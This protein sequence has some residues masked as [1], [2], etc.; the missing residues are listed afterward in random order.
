MTIALDREPPR[1]AADSRVQRLDLG[2]FLDALA[3]RDARI[4]GTAR[5]DASVGG[6]VG[7]DLAATTAGRARLDISDGVVHDFPLVAA[8]NRALRL[9]EGNARDTRF[10]RL[11]ASL[12]IGGG[13]AT[14]SD[15]VLEAGEIRVAASGRIGFDRTLNLR[16]TATLSAERTAEIAA[17]VRELARLRRNGT[18]DLPLA[19]TGTLDNPAFGIDLK[20][21]IERGIG[22][23]LLRRLGKFIRR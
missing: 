12:A 9:S 5:I 14:T 6:P 10:S 16:G 15:L 18:I 11:S 2:A 22:D 20:S 21:A 13:G 23:E 7:G 8:I 1:W 19:I 3:A 17:S 4:D